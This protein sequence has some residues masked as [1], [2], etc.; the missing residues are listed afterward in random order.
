MIN[1]TMERKVNKHKESRKR[2][3]GKRKLNNKR[4]L[5]ILVNLEIK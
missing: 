2:V 1:N 4:L 5:S 3:M